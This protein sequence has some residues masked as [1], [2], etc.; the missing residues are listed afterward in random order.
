MSVHARDTVGLRDF[1]E[2]AQKPW[3]WMAKIQ[4]KDGL[5]AEFLDRVQQVL[6]EMRH[7]KTFLS[8]SLCAHPTDE[9]TFLLFE[10]WKDKDEFFTTQLDR[11]Y[12][13][14]HTDRFKDLVVTR[15]EEHTSELQSLMRSSYAVFCLKKKKQ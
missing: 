3:V 11:E 10:V 14:P 2:R 12:R 8:T 1:E 5:V 15:S 9:N 7:E 13:R 4:I 6:D